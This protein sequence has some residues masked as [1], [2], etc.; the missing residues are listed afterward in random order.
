M[1]GTG[2]YTTYGTPAGD[3]YAFLKK[4]FGVNVPA[5]DGVGTAAPQ[6]ALDPGKETETKSAVVDLAKKYMQ[7]AHQTGDLGYFPTGVDMEFQG[8]P[9][10]TK[11]AWG[12]AT[13]PGGSPFG[14]PANPYAP[15][16]SSPG[17]GKTDGSDKNKDPKIAIADLKPN[18]APGAPGT[19][20]KSPV[21]SAAKIVAASLL[22]VTA[23]NGDSG[24][25][26]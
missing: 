20:T 12:T 24:G 25:N 8:T 14:G 4:L 26:V 19:G 10:V 1:S 2:K 6:V 13:T 23:K 22:G 15:D 17:P 11:V 3:K 7:P 16:I 5:G 18:Y 21:A 9:D